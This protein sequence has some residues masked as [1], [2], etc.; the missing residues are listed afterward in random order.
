MQVDYGWLQGRRKGSALAHMYTVKINWLSQMHF[1]IWQ[2]FYWLRQ[3]KIWSS[4]PIYSVQDVQN[5]CKPIVALMR[6]FPKAYCPHPWEFKIAELS[7]LP[8]A[9][10]RKR[11]FFQVRARSFIRIFCQVPR[12]CCFGRR[13]PIRIPCSKS[14]LHCSF[15]SSLGII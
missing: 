13:I 11:K 1:Y 12:K 10:V 14:V 15:I 6:F 5:T 3:P 9:Q 2:I 4:Q 8:N 7:K